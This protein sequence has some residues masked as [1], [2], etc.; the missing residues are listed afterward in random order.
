MMYS[1]HVR[2][3]ASVRVY[4]ERRIWTLTANYTSRKRDTHVKEAFSSSSSGFCATL[5][6]NHFSPF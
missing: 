5:Q 6:L 3:D 2:W 4:A 1:M